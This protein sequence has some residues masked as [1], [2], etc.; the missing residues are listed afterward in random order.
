VIY[1]ILD[2]MRSAKC[3]FEVVDEVNGMNDSE[4]SANAV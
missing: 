4:N 2:E 1:N 3:Y